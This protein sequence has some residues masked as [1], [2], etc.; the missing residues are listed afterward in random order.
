MATKSSWTFLGNSCYEENQCKDIDIKGTCTRMDILA[1]TQKG[2]EFT[3]PTISY[4]AEI[5]RNQYRLAVFSIWIGKHVRLF[6]WDA[7]GVIVMDRFVWNDGPSALLDFLWRFSG[8]PAED[9]SIDPTVLVTKEEEAHTEKLLKPWAKET[10]QRPKRKVLLYDLITQKVREFLAWPP[11]CVP[12]SLRGRRTSC[13]PVCE[14][15]SMEVGFLK[16]S[17]R[18]NIKEIEEEAVTIRSKNVGYVPQLIR[19]DVYSWWAA[20]KKV[21]GQTTCNSLNTDRAVKWQER[22]LDRFVTDRV[23]HSL[24][25]FRTT[26]EL[27]Q[28]VQHALL[29]KSLVHWPTRDLEGVYFCSSWRRLQAR[30][31]YSS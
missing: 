15:G 21:P 3:G 22:S 19:S 8:L 2:N 4:V 24:K 20:H 1:A 28:A 18:W 12:Y 26:K 17:W 10:K 16:N 23:G 5:F 31:H 6:R 11:L 29:G 30:S 14:M 25:T 7:L 27:I 13:Y 9:Q